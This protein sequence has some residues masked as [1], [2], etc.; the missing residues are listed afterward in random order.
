MGTSPDIGGRTGLGR[1]LVPEY[2]ELE[3]TAQTQVARQS[4]GIVSD[5]IDILF[6]EL[7]G[8]IWQYDANATKPQL[9]IYIAA[10]VN[11][12]EEKEDPE[13]AKEYENL[14][15]KLPLNLSNELSRERKKPLDQRNPRFVVFDNLLRFAAK[16]LVWFK[17]VSKITPKS[18]REQISKFKMFPFGML[19]GW[20]DVAELTLRELE[21]LSKNNPI[22]Q[23]IYHDNTKVLQPFIEGLKEAS[24]LAGTEFQ[25]KIQNMRLLADMTW[26]HYESQEMGN[27]L[28]ISVSHIHHLLT[29][30]ASISYEDE[31]P[32]LLTLGIALD[33]STTESELSG[34]IKKSY[35]KTFR[36]IFSI[37][38]H[39]NEIDHRLLLA[40][41]SF[42]ALFFSSCVTEASGMATFQ[43]QTKKDHTEALQ[44]FAFTLAS[45]LISHSQVLP[46]L[47]SET[48]IIVEPSAET[49]PILTT[50]LELIAM[51]VLINAG[52][53]GDKTIKSAYPLILGMKKPLYHAM[54]QLKKQ[55]AGKPINAEL[56]NAIRQAI[57]ALKQSNESGYLEAIGTAIKPLEE[58]LQNVQIDSEEITIYAKEFLYWL[59]LSIE[60]INFSHMTTRVA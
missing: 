60:K 44:S 54:H 52:A 33:L 37:N 41:A 2:Q 10:S 28:S 53:R 1:P 48:L 25:T 19:Q 23:T 47:L 46:Q 21:L 3:A 29:L 55:M 39:H 13:I 45:G 42:T 18:Y 43:R 12:P 31:A 30:L 51:N 50:T 49:F 26:Q 15:S 5:T 35:T 16:A 4:L 9:P 6:T 36:T 58:S 11:A 59:H 34:W 8:N 22:D 40:M 17:N 38:P 20:I 32:A 57:M 7:G 14:V 56:A 27:V 24:Q